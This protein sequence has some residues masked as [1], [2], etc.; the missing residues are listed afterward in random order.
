MQLV[1]ENRLTQQMIPT[2]WLESSSVW[3]ALLPSLPY[4]ALVR[5]LGKLTEVGLLLP[6]SPATALVVARLIDR[7]RI[8]NSRIHPI[9]LLDA[10]DAYRQEPAAVSS[11]V[12]ALEEAFYMSIENVEP[13]GQR[14]HLALDTSTR[15]TAALAMVFARRE[16]HCTIWPGGITRK[17]RLDRVCELTG[18]GARFFDPARPMQDAEDRGLAVDAFIIVTANHGNVVHALDRYRRS[19]GV[20]AK[21]VVIAL[22]SEVCNA[23]DPDDAFQLGVAGFDASVP[24]VIAEFLR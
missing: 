6:Q 19:S 17:D 2:K 1:E 13:I 23:T 21:L 11:V 24:Q 18:S 8:A 15:A 16:V 10:I 20:A 12:D 9:A 7:K 22:D 3:E 14:I 5:Q 4:D